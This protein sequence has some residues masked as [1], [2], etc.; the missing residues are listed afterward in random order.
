MLGL[1]G[2]IPRPQA[3]ELCAHLG[4]RVAPAVVLRCGVCA[5][6]AGGYDADAW[7]S[8][9]ARTPGHWDFARPLALKVRISARASV[10]A[11]AEALG[12][13]GRR[14]RTRAISNASAQDL[15]N[16]PPHPGQHKR[17]VSRRNPSPERP[18]SSEIPAARTSSRAGGPLPVSRS[19][20][21]AAP[22]LT[23]PKFNGAAQLQAVRRSFTV[24]TALSFR[25]TSLLTVP[26]I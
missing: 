10:C 3:V 25:S 4:L 12:R 1:E 15:D 14:P 24:P 7:C 18:S 11:G 8:W 22:P 26:R 17:S 20:P 9:P 19:P 2:R 6:G 21:C 13:G 16:R 23:H 5:C